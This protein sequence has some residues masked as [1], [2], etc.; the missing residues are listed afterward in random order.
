MFSLFTQKVLLSYVDAWLIRTMFMIGA[1][2]RTIFET[3]CGKNSHMAFTAQSVAFGW[4]P[5]IYTL[6]VL[7]VAPS[8]S[9]T[10]ILRSLAVGRVA[11]R[12]GA[13]KSQW[14]TSVRRRKKG[15]QTKREE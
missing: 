9:V 11:G 12:D 8:V 7:L 6:Y 1:P 4:S 13:L 3:Y 5:W 15:N 10:S 14:T 2:S